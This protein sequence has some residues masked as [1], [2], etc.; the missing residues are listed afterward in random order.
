MVGS[1]QRPSLEEALVTHLRSS[2]PGRRPAVELD[3]AQA[4]LPAKGIEARHRARV[5]TTAQVDRSIY[6]LPPDLRA[7]RATALRRAKRA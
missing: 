2:R 3:A 4:G 1:V 7:F 5:E 6:P